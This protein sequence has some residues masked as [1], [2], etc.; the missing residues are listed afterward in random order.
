MATIANDPKVQK[1][2]KTVP[3][4]EK[5]AHKLIARFLEREGQEEIVLDESLTRLQTI[6]RSMGGEI[7]Q[8]HTQV[9]API[10]TTP[11]IVPEEE[12][13]EEVA[14]TIPVVASAK[15][16]TSD[17]KNK[18]NSAEKAAIKSAKKEAKSAKKEAK[19]SVKKE[20]KEA[21]KSAKK[22][23]RKLECNDGG[24]KR[25]RIRRSDS[26]SD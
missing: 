4:S 12:E 6:C 8:H 20:K 3:V 18:V 23:K 5:M 10:P 2:L 14:T 9:E 19:K 24:G 21:K 13:E 11:M 1:I 22:E 17:K 25:K 26:D 7:I 15:K 16:T